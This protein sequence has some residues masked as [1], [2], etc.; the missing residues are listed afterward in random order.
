[1]PTR[2]QRGDAPGAGLCFILK[3]HSNCKQYVAI[4]EHSQ[5]LLP[6]T[7]NRGEGFSGPRTKEAT[8]LREKLASLLQAL[9]RVATPLWKQ[10][11]AEGGQGAPRGHVLIPR[12]VTWTIRPG[13][14]Y[15]ALLGPHQPCPLRTAEGVASFP[16]NNANALI[17]IFSICMKKMCDVGRAPLPCSGLRIQ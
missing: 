12:W 8:A 16:C 5:T 13:P 10:E 1:M 15:Q 14:H 3:D 6:R 9:T 17:T 2:P 4:R 7:L 11:Q